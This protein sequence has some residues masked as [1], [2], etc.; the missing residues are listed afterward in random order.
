MGYKPIMILIVEDNPDHMELMERTLSNHNTA[1]KIRATDSGEDCWT[2]L[3][4]DKYDAVILD[5]TL[6]KVDGLEVL[7]KIG[8]KNYDVPVIMVTGQGDESIAVEAMKLGASDYIAKSGDYLLTLPFI[9]EKTIERYSVTKER[10]QLEKEIRETKE[11]FENLLE[12]VNDIIYTV[13]TDGRITYVNKR[14]EDYGF[15]RNDLIGREIFALFPK[16]QSREKI[17]D[18]ILGGVKKDFEI[19]YRNEKERIFYFVISCSPLRDENGSIYGITSIARDVTE[20]RELAKKQHEMEIELMEQHKLSSI[21]TLI[22]GI[23]HNL[24]SPLTGIL[25]RSQLLEHRLKKQKAACIRLSEERG[26]NGIDTLLENCD[27]SAKDTIS[28]N[29][30]VERMAEIIK[31]M[32]YKTRHEQTDTKQSLNINELLREE[33]AFLE[34]DMFLKHE[35]TKKYEFSNE[36]PNIKVVYGDFSQ[37]VTNIIRNALDA[38]YGTEKKELTV[39][40]RLSKDHIFVDINDTG[41]GIKEEHMP[42]IFDPFFTTKPSNSSDGSPTGIGLGLHSCYIL[43]KRYDVRIDIKSKPGDTTVTVEIPFKKL[44]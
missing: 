34:A 2:L 18:V 11:Y 33:L 26:I 41:V 13:D 24:N 36:I 37:S 25:G 19:T 43:L 32:M 44:Q 10:A 1:F 35:V 14:V 39:K 31:N 5:Y 7:K 8:E 3:D 6:P 16:E 28:I 12:N 20:T 22:Q 17:Q 9:V 15:S 4:H 29:E 40:T 38:M 27:K 30:N 23:A 21:G 42:K